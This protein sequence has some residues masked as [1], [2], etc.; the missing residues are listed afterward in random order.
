MPPM[1]EGARYVVDKEL[2]KFRYL[3]LVKLML[4]GAR[5]VQKNTINAPAGI[6]IAGGECFVAV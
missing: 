4:P 5:I 2:Q 1:T 6:A 3:G